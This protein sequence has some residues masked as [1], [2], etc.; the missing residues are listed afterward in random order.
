MPVAVRISSGLLPACPFVYSA[1]PQTHY[2]VP[3]VTRY[4]KVHVG[5]GIHTASDGR[6]PNARFQ[7]KRL[8][9][10]LFTRCPPRLYFKAAKLLSGAG[11]QGAN[12]IGKEGKTQRW[13]RTSCS[14]IPVL[15]RC[16][17]GVRASGSARRPWPA[18]PRDRRCRM[19]VAG[20]CNTGAPATHRAGREQAI[21]LP[22]R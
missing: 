15:R 14:L 8:M 4:P 22:L 13:N 5:V 20:R 1:L 17:R 10:R 12:G 19:Q 6:K 18:V 2:D 3:Q 11:K 9:P 7:M 21:A 16:L